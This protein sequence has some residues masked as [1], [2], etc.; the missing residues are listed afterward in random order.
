MQAEQK[1]SECGRTVHRLA[2]TLDWGDETQCDL[3]FAI[4]R[5]DAPVQLA[6]VSNKTRHIEA[7]A[8]V[9]VVRV[10]TDAGSTELFHRLL[11]HR[12]EPFGENF[13]FDGEGISRSERLPVER[14]RA[15]DKRGRGRAPTTGSVRPSGSKDLRGKHIAQSTTPV[16]SRHG[17]ELQWGMGT[18]FQTHVRDWKPRPLRHSYCL[19]AMVVT[20]FCCVS[21]L[22]LEG[23]VL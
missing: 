14:M 2:F 16:D 18:Q 11:K 21:G 3:L 12:D 10:S 7:N 6:R 17:A 20:I 1:S 15:E 9:R 23:S 4:G 8:F 13:K 22:V 5:I 19:I